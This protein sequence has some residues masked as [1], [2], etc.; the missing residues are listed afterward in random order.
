MSEASSLLRRRG[1]HED[2]KV[3]MVELFFDL[4]FV[5]AVTQLSHRLL[6]H[7]DLVGALQTALLLFGVWWVWIYTAWVTNWLDP[8]RMS[9]RLCLFA[10]ML[11]GLVLSASIPQAFAERTFPFIAAYVG[12]Q[13]GRTLFFLWAVR[14]E[15]LSRRRNFQR[16]LV[17]LC[18]S[19][20][21]WIVGAFLDGT[22]RFACWAV[23]LLIEISG[24][25]MYFRVPGLGR[26]STAD[27][28]VHGGHFA[29]RCALFVIIALGESLLVTGATFAEQTWN[30]TTIVAF[31]VDFLGS[32]AMWL[33]YFNTGAGRASHRIEHSDDPGRIARIAYT[34]IHVLIIAGIIV[35]AVADELVLV[36]PGH[37]DGAG[38][39]V[40]LGGPALYLAGNA[41]F[42]WVTNDRRTPPLSHLL[43]LALLLALLPLALSHAFSALALGMATTLVMMF[44]V[45][46]ETV[47]LR[48]PSA[49][50]AP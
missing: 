46:W 26:S 16:I 22:V 19:G 1:G 11:A 8:E 47:A 6:A 21:L 38:I 45:A 28:D 29:E 34:Y 31:V 42:K 18:V 20:L 14:G 3:T 13:V 49:R 44:V 17:W 27:W 32:I 36:H 9:V 5:F 41:L 4:V 10:L 25:A 23:A 2:G 35:C 50:R 43:G 33:V 40:I 39:A 24:P 12:M 15:S 48:R 37:A 7:L 30:T